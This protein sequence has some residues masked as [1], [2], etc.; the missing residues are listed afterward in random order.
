MFSDFNRPEPKRVVEDLEHSLY[1]AYKWKNG[2]HVPNAAVIYY[3]HNT[4]LRIAE[5]VVGPWA[6][7]GEAQA[8]AQAVAEKWL[9]DHS[10]N[11]WN[12]DS[13]VS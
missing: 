8:A 2:E 6:T 9:W 4:V 5:I 3:Y 11:N 1:V 13:S 10:S 7:E 12:P